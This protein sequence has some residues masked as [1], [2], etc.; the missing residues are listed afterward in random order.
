MS[1]AKRYTYACTEVNYRRKD[2]PDAWITTD[3]VNGQMFVGYPAFSFIP[4]SQGDAEP[5]RYGSFVVD[6][7]TGK[8]ACGDAVKILDWFDRVYSIGP[9]QWRIYLS[10]KKGVHLDLPEEILGTEGGNPY[11]SLGYKRLALEIEGELGIKLDTSMYN[12][13]TG[14]PYRQS[15]VMRDC[16]TCKRQI[17]YSDLAEI[18]SEE[19]YRDACKEPGPTWQ[20]TD[21]SRNV[22]LAAKMEQYLADAEKHRE[23]VKAAPPLTDEEAARLAKNLPSCIHILANLTKTTKG[24]TFND[25]AMQLTAYAV[26]AGLTEGVFLELCK[27]FIE[28]YPSSSLDTIAKR[29]ENCKARYRTMAANGNGH[30]CRGILAMKIPGYDCGLCSLVSGQSGQS[31]QSATFGEVVDL[32]DN[33]ESPAFPVDLLPGVVA[34]YARD[35][36]ELIGVDAGVIGMAAIGAMAGC[37]DDRIQ[38]QPKRHDPTWLESARLWI[39]IIGD[40]ST[41]KSPGIKKAISPVNRVAEKWRKQHQESMKHWEDACYQAKAEDKKARLPPAPEGKRLTVGDT[42]V[43]KLGDILSKQEPRGILVIRDELSGFLTSMDAYKN[44][45]GKDRSA[46]L[47][48][49]NGGPLE[50][51][52]IGRGSFFVP[53]WSASVVGGIQLSVIDDYANVTN[54]DGMLQRF[55]LYNATPA[56]PG[57]DRQP[58]MKA[59]DLYV[60]LIDHLAHLQPADR[61]VTL[62]EDA[63]QVRE[64]FSSRL[65][66]LAVSTPNKH[67]SAML[68]KWEGT[69]ARLLLVFHCVEAKE[70]W[71]HPQEMQVSGET[72]AKVD[73][74]LWRVILPHS[75]AFYSGID[76]AEKS[77]RQLAGL[78]LA[79]EWVRFTVK[80]DLHNYMLAYRKMT[81]REREGMLDHLEA[82]GWIR[83]EPG[84]LSDRGKPTAYEVN[85]HV[86]I[87]F[88]DQAEKERQKRADCVEVLNGLKQPDVDNVVRARV[89]IKEK[90]SE[91]K[92]REE[93]PLYATYA[94][95]TSSTFSSKEGTNAEYL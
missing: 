20:P 29:Y 24:N 56:P 92:E 40:P 67:L 15:N 9:D 54:H 11:L 57:K 49:Y 42:T 61:P 83:P 48:A 1:G 32:F 34:D 53:N 41:K 43:E 26:S 18:T 79:R 68:G 88:K 66:K 69:F 5:I 74:L 90:S 91:N 59:K 14:K 35:Q 25:I 55:L 62:T 93:I 58:N 45:G 60:E 10:G 70:K 31:D 78:V 22:M 65:H 36:S 12:M 6:I 3:Q 47:E 77:A 23:A 27:P 30:S 17:E 28:R 39:S 63:H 50:I 4:G 46:W 81:D 51:D 2:K 82:Y 73:G 38:I 33:M 16:G 71:Q 37:I 76:L 72:A 64:A 13:G 8:L 21:T 95:T 19:E 87:R 7:D 44:G 80:R 75:I 94:R 84:K 85:P 89:T 52:R 86:H